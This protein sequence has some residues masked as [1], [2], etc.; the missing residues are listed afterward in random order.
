M[1]SSRITSGYKVIENLTLYAKW[2]KKDI[3]S[4]FDAMRYWTSGSTATAYYIYDYVDLE[5]LAEVVNSGID[6][7]GVTI[8]QRNNIVIN[9]SVLGNNFEEPE[10]AS[11]GEPNAELINFAGIGSKNNL[12]AGTAPHP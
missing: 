10:E 3:S 2:I 7:A 1:E 9:T 8:T 12:F 6:L 11:T 4:T 5:K